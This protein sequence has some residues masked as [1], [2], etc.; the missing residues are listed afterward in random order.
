MSG[1]E[2]IGAIASTAQLVAY[3]ITVSSKLNEVRCNIRHTPKRLE[4]YDRQ[5]KDLIAIIEHM[6]TNPSIRTK[7]LDDCLTT[8]LARAKAINGILE[9]FQQ[10]SRSRRR[11]N[12]ISG[13]LLRQLDECFRDVRNTMQNIVVLIVSQSAHDQHELKDELKE[14]IAGIAVA[15]RQTSVITPVPRLA[16]S[17]VALAD[18]AN[19]KAGS[20]SF[21]GLIIKDSGTVSI[22]NVSSPHGTPPY[23][24]GHL[25]SGFVASGNKVLHIGNTGGNSEGHIF[26]DGV[27]DK[28]ESTLLGDYTDL[29]QKLRHISL[30]QGFV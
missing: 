20:H 27:M 12:I 2:V 10:S 16:N 6:K 24:A 29:E 13:D 25:F 9:K 17:N 21:K 1:L 18:C 28:N 26:E 23:M 22:G 19:R 8:I 15:A 11:W 30:Q 14:L 7:E 5:F 4:H 3:V